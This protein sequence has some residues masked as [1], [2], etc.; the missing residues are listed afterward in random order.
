MKSRKQK[1]ER[2]ERKEAKWEFED[3]SLEIATDVK[4]TAEKQ[5][6][7]DRGWKTEDRR[8]RTEDGEI[9]S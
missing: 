2:R 5:R 8:R 6:I 4:T 9:E 3:R 7:E 1:A